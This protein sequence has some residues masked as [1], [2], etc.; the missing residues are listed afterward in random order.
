MKTLT[1][2]QV[3]QHMADN[4]R[5][6]KSPVDG[7]QIEG[8]SRIGEWSNI[9]KDISIDR[10]YKL[11]GEFR[12]AP[13]THTL[14]GY[15]VPAPETEAPESGAVYYGLHVLGDDGVEDYEWEGDKHDKNALR[16]GLWL[17]K[18]DAIAN[19]KAMRGE[20]PYE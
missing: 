14:N 15:D 17:S 18:E 7:L 8:V 13:R 11:D 5:V 9:N 19:A 16:H 20:D 12:I 2:A 3:F 4:V 6:G 1:K 10:L